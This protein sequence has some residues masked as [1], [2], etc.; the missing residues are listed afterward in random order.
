[1]ELKSTIPKTAWQSGRFN[2]RPGPSKLLFGHM[3]EDATIELAAFP[4]VGRIFCI[5]SAGCTAMQL[6]AYHDVIAVDLNPIQVAYVRRRLA[7]GPVELGSADRILGF[8]RVLAPLAGWSKSRLR[9]FLNLDD[10]KE[11]ISYWRKYLNTGRF[12]IAFDFLLSRFSLRSIYSRTFLN[13][14]PQNFGTILRAR[15]ERCFATHSNRQ[16]PYAW[17][18]LLGEKDFEQ[19]AVQSKQIKLACAD[20][21][22]FLEAQPS[23]SFSGFSLSN[24]VDGTNNDYKRRLLDAVRNAAAPGAPVVLRSFG[25][26]QS[27]RQESYAKHDRSMLWG[28]VDVRPAHTL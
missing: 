4:T 21:I 11:Q 6:S 18:L 14:L 25:E 16:N 8:G 2:P 27:S 24:I 15:M 17:L 3:Y 13:C 23:G 19:P 12:R 20:A 10:P 22:A 26:P 9:A 1:M 28:V 7:G 5:A